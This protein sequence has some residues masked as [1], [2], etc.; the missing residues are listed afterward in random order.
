MHRKT[1]GLWFYTNENGYLIREQ[2][3][4][5]MRKA[6]LIV[7][8]D[9]DMRECY[10]LNG[11]VYTKDH[12]NLSSLDV[13]YYMNAEERNAHQHDMLKMIEKSGVTMFNPYESYT[14]ANDKFVANCIL[15][16]HGVNVA[17]SMLLPT[18][19]F[20]VE[21]AKQIF[22]E[23]KAVVV[24]PRDK[25]CATGIM[26]FDNFEAFYDFYLFAKEFVGNLYVERFIPFKERDIRVEVFNGEVVGDGFS[27][28]MGH[29]FK[30]N[31][32]SGGRATYI[33]AEE[34]AKR[35]ALRAAK[36]LGM[37]T[38]IVDMVRS[39]EDGQ[40]YVL[41][42]NPLL[43]VFYGAHF[44]SVGQEVPPYFARMD[45]LKIELIADH[46]IALADLA[47]GPPRPERG[48]SS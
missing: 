6:G 46:I 14:Y 3:V 39:L 22:A 9:F 19:N 7:V 30:T 40:P 23:W 26:K 32:K 35:M 12:F 36:A 41:E 2:I 47:S 17:P 15:R 25:I 43:G 21:R 13:F 4:E 44:A 38:T 24:K 37:T 27:R 28:L 8:Y 29:S 16:Q 45:A 33:P 31:V 42:V 48:I 5:R 10:C 11:N 1:A 20:P 34:D 18:A